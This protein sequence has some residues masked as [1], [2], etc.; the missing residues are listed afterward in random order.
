[1]E[2]IQ[3]LL[4]GITDDHRLRQRNEASTRVELID[5]ILDALGWNSSEI[6]REVPSGAGSYLD[7]ELCAADTQWMVVEAKRAGA[8]FSLPDLGARYTAVHSIQTLLNRGG[9]HLREALIQAATYCNDRGIPHAAISNGTQWVI[10]RGLSAKDRPWTKGVAVAFRSPEEIIS[11]FD[12][13]FGCLARSGAGTA[14]LGRILD[15]PALAAPPRFSIP[16]DVLTPIRPPVDSHRLSLLRS[17]AD[18]LFSDIFGEDRGSMLER[19]YVEPGAAPEFERSLQRLLRDTARTL[20]DE[21]DRVIEGDTAKF[22]DELSTQERLAKLSHPIVVVGHVGAGKTTFIHRALSRLRTAHSAMF[23][24]VDLE[25]YG[26]SGAVDAEKEERAVATQILEKLRNAATTVLKHAGLSD[27]E[28]SQAD[29]F[30]ADTLRT[31]FRKE[32]DRERN[33]GERLWTAQPEKWIEKEYELI[34]QGQSDPRSLLVHFVRHLRARFRRPADN[35][36]YP[37]LII[38]DNLDQSSDEYQRCMYAFA[39]RLARDTPCVMLLCLREDT[40]L[41]GRAAGGFLTSSPLQFVFH[42]SAPPLDRLVHQRVRFGQH[43]LAN[44]LLPSG[45]K[46]E[47]R[48]VEE[49]CSFVSGTLLA[50]KATSIELIDGLAGHNVREALE[51]VRYT[52]QGWPSARGKPNPTA[53]FVLDCLLASLGTRPATSKLLVNCFDADP[54]SPPLHG[55]RVRLLAYYSWA[56]D[57]APEKPYLE[58]T[59][60]VI[61]RFNAWGYP[62]ALIATAIQFLLSAGLLRVFDSPE[63]GRRSLTA[64]LPVR[65]TITAAGQVHLTSLMELPAYRTA[66]A[67]MTRWYDEESAMLFVERARSAGGKDGPTIGDIVLSSGHS[68]FDAYLA[69]AMATE[70]ALLSRTVSEKAWAAEVLARAAKIITA[71]PTSRLSAVT[72]QRFTNGGRRTRSKRGRDSSQL[73]LVAAPSSGSPDLPG[74]RPGVKYRNTVWIPRILWALEWS[75]RSGLGPLSASEIADILSNHGETGVPGPNV[76]RA[77]RAAKDTGDGETLWSISGRRYTITSAGQKVILSLLSE[78]GA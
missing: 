25:G 37:V 30:V 41:R 38:L 64:D 40:Y 5:R 32:L 77:F 55:L 10:F 78:D 46:N 59:E 18:F 44:G 35:L 67:C 28:R 20:D 72:T 73:D 69:Q 2:A 21:A 29:P 54:H 49:V 14:Y 6:G 42:V 65:T 48:S 13:F 62:V 36:R 76:A 26:V 9:T 11:R 58:L 63:R 74:L 57:L 45:L 17:A 3:G 56:Y 70:D 23:A 66:M 50:P 16:R 12:E 53:A 47:A 8:T 19:C 7:Y 15:R 52:I 39:Q 60:G 51:S 71:P 68:V 61:A 34:K 22:I 33:L 1:L 24:L 4:S 75:H 43:A 31:L 27:A